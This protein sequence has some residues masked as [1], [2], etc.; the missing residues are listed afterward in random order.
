MALTKWAFQGEQRISLEQ[1]QHCNLAM[2]Q[3]ALQVAT[4][5][6]TRTSLYVLPMVIKYLNIN[7]LTP[8]NLTCPYNMADIV[9]HRQALMSIQA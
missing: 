8:L 6:S 1:Q 3:S 7:Q 9:W 5:T 2:R 4:D